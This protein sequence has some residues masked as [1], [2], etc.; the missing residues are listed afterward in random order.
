MRFQ[1]KGPFFRRFC[2]PVVAQI[3]GQQLGEAMLH[4]D[5]AILKYFLDFLKYFYI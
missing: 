3:S 1:S 5:K 2:C 4:I